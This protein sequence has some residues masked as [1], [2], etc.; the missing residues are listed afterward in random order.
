MI[1]LLRDKPSC[2][3]ICC[4]A[5]FSDDK[6]KKYEEIQRLK[7]EINDLKKCMCLMQVIFLF[8]MQM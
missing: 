2:F 6:A 7:S 8:K 1:G 4:I 5:Y 3:L